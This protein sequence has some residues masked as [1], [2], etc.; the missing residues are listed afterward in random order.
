MFKSGSK[1]KKQEKGFTLIEL[2]VVA[3]IIG[4]LL[5]LAI[6][7]LIKA[8]VSANEANA[9]KMMQTLRDAE[10]EYFEQD[11]DGDGTRDYT[12]AIG[13]D[14]TA[15]S[16]RYP[17]E[18]DNFSEDNALVDS[19]F[20]GADVNGG[21]PGTGTPANATC[22]SPKA[23]YCVS[24]H[25]PEDAGDEPSEPFQ[26]FGW[27]ASPTSVNKTG[28]KD[29]VVFADGVIRCTVSSQGTGSPGVFEAKRATGG[30]D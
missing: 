24:W 8:R 20:E 2:L 29:F 26:D 22:D 21:Q 11:L 14:S 12:N 4:I 1:R 23:G 28:R 16:L 30:C 17:N 7:N 25:W 9:R 19:S 5:A 27:G 13:D 15:N 6:P 3:A 10:G 18:E